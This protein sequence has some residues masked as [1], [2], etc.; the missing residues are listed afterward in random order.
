MTLL[1]DKYTMHEDMDNVLPQGN[2]EL[3]Y[4][5]DHPP[6]AVYNHLEL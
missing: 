4:L 3:E 2:V 1:A 6:T 5:V